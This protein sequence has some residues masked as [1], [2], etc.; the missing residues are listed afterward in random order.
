[1][2][3]DEELESQPSLDNKLVRWSLGGWLACVVEAFAMI[4]SSQF[5][6]GIARMVML[7]LSLLFLLGCYCFWRQTDGRPVARSFVITLAFVSS[8]AVIFSLVPTG[9]TGWT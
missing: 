1:M 5:P 4:A 6:Y 7:A 9:V 2:N 3:T 8:I